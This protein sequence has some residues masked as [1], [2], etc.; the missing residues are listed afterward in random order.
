MNDRTRMRT[1]GGVRRGVDPSLLSQ[2]KSL[3]S[4]ETQQ[5][6][7]RPI[8]RSEPHA[9]VRGGAGDRKVR[10]N[11]RRTENHITLIQLQQETTRYDHSF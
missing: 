11:H 7:S 3:S 1:G 6:Y 2:G 8:E 5:R 10:N 4:P 9:Y